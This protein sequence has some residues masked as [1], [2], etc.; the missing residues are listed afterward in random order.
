[1]PGTSNMDNFPDHLDFLLAAMPDPGAIAEG[2][3]PQA[4]SYDLPL[5]QQK[6]QRATRKVYGT[7]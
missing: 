5:R 4:P 3:S 6:V 1:M 7:K 2:R